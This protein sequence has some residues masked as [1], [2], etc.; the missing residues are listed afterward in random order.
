MPPLPGS[1]TILV[2]DDEVAVL[3]LTH[4]MLSRYGYSVILAHNGREALHLFETWPEVDVHLALLDVVMPD[5]DGVQLANKLRAVRPGL[6]LL[7]MSAYSGRQE[8]RTVTEKGVPYIPKPFT[9][10]TLTTKIREILDER[11]TRSASDKAD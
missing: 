2:V 3:S 7:F 8:V 5:M 9:S 6:P 10:V 1:E 11:R 4:S